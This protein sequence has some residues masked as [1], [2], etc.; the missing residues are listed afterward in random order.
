[1]NAPALVIWVK[2][3]SPEFIFNRS[4]IFPAEL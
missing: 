4:V 1:M 2:T 3:S